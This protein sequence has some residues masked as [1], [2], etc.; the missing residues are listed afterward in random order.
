MPP[1][2]AGHLAGSLVLLRGVGCDSI[3]RRRRARGQGAGS[4][5]VRRIRLPG[6]RCRHPPAARTGR[7]GAGR[8]HAARRLC[9]AVARTV[10]TLAGAAVSIVDAG[11]QVVGYSTHADQPIDDVRRQTTLALRE[12][13]PLS[14]DE[15]YRAVLGSRSAVHLPSENAGQ[16]G[17]VA[18]AVR[19][20]GELLG[21]VRVMQ[22][23][24]VIRTG[25]PVASRPPG[26]HLHRPAGEHG[27]AG[28]LLP[29]AQ[30]GR[31][32][33]RGHVG[34]RVRPDPDQTVRRA[35]RCPGRRRRGGNR[36]THGDDDPH[37]AI[38]SGCRRRTG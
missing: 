8:Q 2:F 3:G 13:Q 11:G 19:S 4:G 18:R 24:T 33:S 27:C 17:R 29:I 16:F 20:A 23:H 30:H 7:L 31:R 36:P 34:D 26:R 10:A 6:N 14:L 22:T 38:P 21:A 37:R 5:P 12:T 35:P 25:Y 15:D 32:A 9:A 1:P 28:P